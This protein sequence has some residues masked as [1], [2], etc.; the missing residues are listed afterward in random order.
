MGALRV[1]FIRAPRPYLNSKDYDDVLDGYRYFVIATNI[2]QHEWKDKKVIDFYRKRANCEN[3]I[4]E[5]KYGMDFR[6]KEVFDR[7]YQK[8]KNLLARF[9]KNW[10]FG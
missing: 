1:V 4:K 10:T 8:L 7:C 2:F 9:Y 3:F 6:R 5:Q